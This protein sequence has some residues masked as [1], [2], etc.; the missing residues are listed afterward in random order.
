M[1]EFSPVWCPQ[2]ALLPF[3]IE[4][5]IYLTI[6]NSL[7]SRFLQQ[8]PQQ[9][10]PSLHLGHL[11]QWVWDL[12]QPHLTVL[13][14]AKNLW[15]LQLHTLQIYSIEFMLLYTEKL[16]HFFPS[17]RRIYLPYQ[18][19]LLYQLLKHLQQIHQFITVPLHCLKALY[20]LQILA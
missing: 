4:E 3:S 7:K 16:H 6:F 20:F 12:V 11:Q 2:V 14:I 9:Q 10:H 19:D 13:L 1:C 8:L 15:P 18:Q 5:T 17:P